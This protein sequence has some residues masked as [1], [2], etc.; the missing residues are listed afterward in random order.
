MEG[1]YLID[2]NRAS[3]KKI[4]QK[5]LSEPESQYIS[6]NQFF[7]FCCKIKLY[8]ELIS[9][10]ELKRIA[11]S[12]LKKTITED[13]PIEIYYLS[14]EKILKHIAEHCFPSKNSIKHLISH[15]RS[16]CQ[17][18]YNTLLTTVAPIHPL[19]ESQSTRNINAKPLSISRITNSSY[20][21]RKVL[22]NSTTQKNLNKAEVLISPREKT[23]MRI[24]QETNTPRLKVINIKSKLNES[25]KILKMNKIL[26]SFQKTHKKLIENTN[27]RKVFLKF[28]EKFLE[29][30]MKNVKNIQAWVY[31]IS[32]QIWRMKTLVTKN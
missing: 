2:C 11:S 9:S 15:I 29:L 20:Q 31:Q 7:K 17:I 24:I 8:P 23:I 12:I 27:P 5:H 26:K 3:L 6:Y 21:K 30:K 4:F 13:K 25:K 19:Y 22:N 28:V 14:F 10:T 1:D 18:Y 32:F 16:F